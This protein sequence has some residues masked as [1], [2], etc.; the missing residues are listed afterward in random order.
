M[1]PTH[2]TDRSYGKNIL[3]RI[4][5][6]VISSIIGL[7]LVEIAVRWSGINDQFT[8]RIFSKNLLEMS[9]IRRLVY[10]PKPGGYSLIDGV[11]NRIS[12]QGLRDR[13]FQIPK[14]DGIF[15]IITLGDSVTYGLGVTAE[16]TYP[17]V[18]ESLL[19]TIASSGS[20]RC[21]VLNMGVNGYKTTQE[22][23]HLTAHG[24]RFEPDLVILAYNLNDPGDFSRELP[25]FRQW[26]SQQW[27]GTHQSPW[28]KIRSL[29]THY[30][31]LAFMIE[32]RTL[33]QKLGAIATSDQPDKKYDGYFHLYQNTVVMNE[34][35][36]AFDELK[37]MGIHHHFRIVFV[38]FPLL[39]DF[40]HYRWAELHDTVIQMARERGFLTHDILP[41]FKSSQKSAPDLQRRPDDVEHPNEAGHEIA[42]ESIGQFLRES[43]LVHFNNGSNDP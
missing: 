28:K 42:A 11:E 12:Q 37:Q 22:V 7:F 36:S 2:H 5:L 34:L 23:A 17:K 24:L 25:Y 33:R 6:L 39:I 9:D 19:N 1:E 29:L 32:Y 13:E 43:G 35:G 41:A 40:D 8:R 18:L 4:L 20:L 38:I 15:R 27:N 26:Q 21:E 16:A 30:S 3:F 10:E 14:P 31:D